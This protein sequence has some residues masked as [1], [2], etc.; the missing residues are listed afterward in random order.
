MVA[1][2]VLEIGFTFFKEAIGKIRDPQEMN[3]QMVSVVILILSIGVKLWLGLFNRKLGK[4]ID[5]KVM[6]LRP[7]TLWAMW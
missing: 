2:L 5:S 4:R 3:F 7:R 1:F 6:L